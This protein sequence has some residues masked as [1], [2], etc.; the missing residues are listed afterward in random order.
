MSNLTRDR[1]L[2]RYAVGIDPV[3]D[4][5]LVVHKK[6]GFGRCFRASLAPGERLQRSLL[7]RANSFVAYAVPCDRNLRHDFVRPLKTH[8]Q[9]HSF[10]LKLSLEYRVSDPQLLVE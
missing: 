6:V 1:N 4:H 9:I 8:D 2:V 10:E 7:E 5:Y 3:P